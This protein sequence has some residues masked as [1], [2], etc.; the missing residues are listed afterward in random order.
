M[1]LLEDGKGRV[2]LERRPPSGIWGGLWSLPE[3]EP[4][5]D[6]EQWCRQRL[7]LEVSPLERWAPRRH[8]F[9]HF[10]LEI[11]PVRA[12]VCGASRRVMEGGTHFWYKL[13]AGNGDTGV[14][15]PVRRLLEH[16]MST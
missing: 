2:L 13:G 14:P 6:V 5:A 8:G 7:G 1:L 9:T 11:L 12:C 3:A 4:E 10:E 16:L 15:A